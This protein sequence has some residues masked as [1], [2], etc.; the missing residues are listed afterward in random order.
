VAPDKTESSNPPPQTKG[1]TKFDSEEDHDSPVSA[2]ENA[3][4]RIS[5][6]SDSFTGW[7]FGALREKIT[8]K[9]L[10][11]WIK[12]MPEYIEKLQNELSG[13]PWSLSWE[14]WEDAHD[15]Q[16]NPEV[17]WDA[18]VRLSKE[19]CVDERA[20]LEYRRQHTT[21]ALAKYLDVPESEIHPDDVP[22]IG[23]CG[24]GGGL[25]ALVAG[26]SSALCAQQSGLFDC[27]T[28]TSGVSGSCWLQT[29]FNSS[30]G[31]QDYSR[32]IDHLK[33]RI[34]IHIAYPP[35]ALK[36]LSAAPTNKFLLSGYVE[37]LRGVP[38]ADFGLVDIYGLLLAARLMIPK[39]ELN[40]SDTDLKVSNQRYAIEDGNAP[41]PIY[42]AVRHEIPKHMKDHVQPSQYAWYNTKHYDFFEWFEW[43]PFEFFCEAWECGIPTWAV[44]RQ[45]DAGKTEWRENG[46]ALP[47]LRIPLYLGIWGSAFCATLSH[48]YKEIRPIL[49]AAGLDK[50]DTLLSGK[51]DDLVKVHPIDP[52]VIPNFA[53]GLKDRL[54]DTV[55]ESV[56]EADHLQL[57]DAGMSNNLPI[58]PL[59]RPGRNVDVIIA[60]DASADVKTDNWVKVA[61][62]YARYV[63]RW[64]EE[65]LEPPGRLGYISE[66][67]TEPKPAESWQ[68]SLGA[69]ISSGMSPV[70]RY[71]AE[72]LFL[73]LPS[74]SY[75]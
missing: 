27:V 26:A 67:T 37:K 8:E 30:I 74:L 34:N 64:V 54:P 60:F 31:Q 20:F 56:H 69:A 72:F 25:R 58:Y 50:L 22:I 21:K 2:W 52:A 63:N 19:L 24:S 55:P 41:L 29:L 73:F 23:L 1:H 40:V 4:N 49:R 17:V 12:M 32:I 11:S 48:Y 47:E 35:A 70:G 16:I 33:Q 5:E 71:V 13:A 44:G 15:P 39:G 36:L 65:L 6:A 68:S 10:P 46:L 9:I 45:W 53:L 18:R 62:G 3:T 42:T 14:I 75:I 51:D 57:M 66:R 43:S 7:D 28:Y 59:L 38:D 61:D